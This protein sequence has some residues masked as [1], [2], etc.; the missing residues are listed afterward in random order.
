MYSAIIPSVSEK[1]GCKIIGWDANLL[2]NCGESSKKKFRTYLSALII[3]MILWGTIGF[4]FASNYMNLGSPIACSFVALAFML[5][6]LCIERV[7]ILS[8]KSKLMGW[9]RFFLALCMATLGASIFDQ[10]IFKNDIQQEVANQRDAQT[11]ETIQIRMAGIEADIAAV[12][13]QRDSLN[14]V[15]SVLNEKISANPTIKI[16]N[17]S[18]QTVPMGVDENGKTIYGKQTGTQTSQVANPLIQQAE[19]NSR[20][21]EDFNAQIE[22]LYNQKRNV[23]ADTREEIQNRKAGFIEELN[24]TIKVIGKSWVSIV[25]YSVMFA[26]LLFLEMFVLSISFG[27]IKTDY[28]MRVEMQLAEAQ[29]QMNDMTNA[30]NAPNTALV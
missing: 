9:M 1:I 28:E 24:A 4:C 8:N 10:L 20:Q 22:K 6:I 14:T 2:A 7:I 19:M 21:I 15:N 5:I 18:S 30:R 11:N 26:F 29:R 3:M 27:E 16:V 17:T 25:F 13:F 12:T 23:E